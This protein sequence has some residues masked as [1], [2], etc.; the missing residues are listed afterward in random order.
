MYQMSG[1]ASL[2]HG[3][4]SHTVNVMIH[5]AFG[6]FALIVGLIP[7]VTTKGGTWHIRSGRWFLSALAVVILTAVT[8][9]VFFRFRPFLGVITLLAA[10][11]AYSG[12]RALRIRYTGP[13]L[14]DGAVSVSGIAA[15]ILLLAYVRSL[16]IPWSPAVIYPT[17]GALVG[18]SLYD[19]HRFAFPKRWFAK[20]WIYE[21]LIKMLGAYNA[22][23]SAFS[24]TVLERWQPYSQIVPSAVATVVTIGFIIYVRR[25]RTFASPTA[26]AATAE[27]IIPARAGAA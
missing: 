6:T 12:F 2:V 15:A 11:Q 17:L 14:L 4:I 16:H 8:G 22:V 24:G 5:V 3:S 1:G 23:V 25:R 26:Q 9:I 21:H 20:T 10:Y 13:N 18:V 19:L 7:L 27:S